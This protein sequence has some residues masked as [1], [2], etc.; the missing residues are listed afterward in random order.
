MFQGKI[1]VQSQ[2]FLLLL[3]ANLNAVLTWGA[4]GMAGPGVI[5]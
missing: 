4:P 3:G 5:G 1:V 2:R